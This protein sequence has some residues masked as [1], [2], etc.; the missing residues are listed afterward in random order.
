VY[1]RMGLDPLM[2]P[3]SA[4]SWPGYV[5]TNEPLKLAAGHFGLGH[6]GG[7]HAPDEFYLIESTD[8]RIQGYGGATR[9]FA[10]YLAELATIA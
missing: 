1:K 10:A 6:G 7:A 9:S 5:F 2:F 8:P 4:G 3:R